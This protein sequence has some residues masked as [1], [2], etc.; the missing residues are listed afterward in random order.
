MAMYK[1]ILNMN[2]DYARGVDTKV[3]NS[4][5]LYCRTHISV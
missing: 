2:M 5:G 3:W 4:S 1:A